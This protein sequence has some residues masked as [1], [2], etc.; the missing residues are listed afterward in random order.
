MELPVMQRLKKELE[1]LRHELK[2]KLPKELE[3]GARARRSARKRGVRSVQGAAGLSE[4]AHRPDSSSASATC[5]STPF[6]RF[7]RDAIGYGSRVTLES[8]DGGRGLRDRLS[9]RSR[10]GGGAD[11]DRLAARSG[12]A[13]Q[14]SRR[15]SRGQHAKGQ[16]HLPNRRVADHSTSAKTSALPEPAVPGR[17]LAVRRQ[18]SR[19][20]APVGSVRAVACGTAPARACRPCGRSQPCA[21]PS[22]SFSAAD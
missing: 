9:R 19:R 4:R 2:T 13:Q 11:L 17:R 8:D 12:L 21:T 3:D 18:V 5:R 1:E 7:P 14:G 20:P 10:S 16:A 6:I 15:R 22:M